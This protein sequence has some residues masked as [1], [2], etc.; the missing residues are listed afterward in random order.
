MADLN[1]LKIAVW[2]REVREDSPRRSRVELANAVSRANSM[3]A[4]CLIT[5]TFDWDD[6]QCIIPCNGAT[7][8]YGTWAMTLHT[9]AGDYDIGMGCPPYNCDLSIKFADDNWVRSSKPKS[10]QSIEIP[11]IEVGYVGM[12]NAGHSV[13]CYDGG[14]TVFDAQGNALS[15]F[16]DD[17]ED[18][19]RIVS[20]KEPGT[21]AEPCE[22][23]LLRALSTTIRRFDRQ[24]LGGSLNWIIGL[25]GGLDSS[26]VA[27][28]LVQAIGKDRVLGYSLPTG[29]N[30]KAT[31][32]NAANL[33]ANL[34]IA[35]RQA[36]IEDIVVAT[37]GALAHSGYGIDAMSG[38]VLE[39]VQARIRG[40]LLCTFAA[41]EKGVVVNNGNFVE[42]S[43]GY[44]TLYGDSVGALAPIADLAKTDLFDLARQLNDSFGPAVIPENLLPT[45]TE[46]SLLWETMPSAELSSGQRDPMKWF[47]HDWLVRKLSIGGDDAVLDVVSAYADDKLES[48]GML[49]WIEYYGLDKPEAFFEDIE[50]VLR[51]MRSAAFKRIQSAPSILVISPN[52]PFGDAEIQRRWE[53]DDRYTELKEDIL[54]R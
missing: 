23:K 48:Q 7:A 53:P 49:R 25:S 12:R 34:G 8:E 14:T 33:A 35:F 32:D 31:K 11:S 39:N 3:G 42:S 44:S 15:V 22:N 37:D 4:D 46:D 10:P 18:E 27:A 16:R 52:S 41:V 6:E 1:E 9:D 2:Q 43:L 28:L 29:F 5:Y 17:F 30:S 36:P 21:V 45:V 51:Q 13:K 26:T 20:L 38:L 40:H 24:V 19:F 50:W 47:Y 54:N